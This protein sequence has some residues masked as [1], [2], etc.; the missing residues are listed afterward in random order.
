MSQEI[1]TATAP[2]LARPESSPAAPPVLATPSPV[3]PMPPRRR[4]AARPT[5]R[6][7]LKR[8]LWAALA[9]GIG[10]A[11]ALGLRQAPVPVETAAAARG[12]LR[13]TVDEDGRT[14]VTDRY[15]ISAPLAA[16]VARPALRAGDTVQQGQVV[17]RL[18]PLAPPLLDPRARREAEARVAAARAAL[19]QADAAVAS[20]AAAADFAQRTASR[21][22]AMLESG[23]TSRQAVDE[24]ELAARTQHEEFASAQFGKRVAGSEL[25]LAQ[26]ALA[27][28]DRA[29]G[30]TDQ[31]IVRAPV[32]GVVLR[33]FQESEGVV[34]PGSP[35]MEIGDPAALE[36]VVD[37]LTTD[38]VNIRPGAFVRL[39]RWGGD[40]ALSGHVHRVEP[41]A[42]TK[43][44]ALGVEEQ[45]VNVV[46][47]LDEPR[48]RW[49]DLGDGFRVEASILTWE[50]RNRLLV[51]GGAIFRRG[52]GWAVYVLETG[53]ARL[54][55][56]DTGRRNDSAIEITGGL[57]E[58]ERVVLYP[59]DN[60]ADGV[61]VAER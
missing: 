36:A 18:V 5:A 38:A 33:L 48:S 54:R 40:S 53:R 49:A 46:I 47:H 45:R 55:E 41:S 19:S 51:P 28:L 13:V 30:S 50:G 4:L 42:F 1:I 23:A 37:V 11:V 59:T 24:A 20:A 15:T 39:E 8:T 17:A 2:E 61:R 32:R 57:R 34:Q 27:R 10:T 44:S 26:A 52:E 29:P 25:R 7:A 43:L 21:E 14:R 22:R 60:V 56:I 6:R 9:V 3:Q 16:T 58:G 12:T 31:F 35:L